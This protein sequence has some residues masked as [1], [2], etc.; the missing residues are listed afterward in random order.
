V[1]LD[2]AQDS[3]TE[4]LGVLG[5]WVQ[6][7]DSNTALDTGYHVLSHFLFSLDAQSGQELF[8]PV[9]LEWGDDKLI[10]AM[11]FFLLMS[12]FFLTTQFEKSAQLL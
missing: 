5:T 8:S 3:V 4:V 12:S 1:Y 6:G 9:A 2:K 10:E 11:W 7:L